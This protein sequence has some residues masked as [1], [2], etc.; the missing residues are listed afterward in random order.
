MRTFSRSILKLL[1]LLKLHQN[2]GGQVIRMANSAALVTA[3]GARYREDEDPINPKKLN[4]ESIIQEDDLAVYNDQVAEVDHGQ[5]W[6]LNGSSE[7]NS[8]VPKPSLKKA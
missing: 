5:D 2:I 3:D 8:I 1:T 7:E 4:I 6:L